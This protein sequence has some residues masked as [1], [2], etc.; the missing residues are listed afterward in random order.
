MDALRGD[1]PVVVKA[2]AAR[3]VDGVW[4]PDTVDEAPW[5]RLAA[6]APEAKRLM[7]LI[8]GTDDPLTRE[9]N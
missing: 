1:E 8:E 7:K 4:L 2:L 3:W 9:V 5:W 6:V